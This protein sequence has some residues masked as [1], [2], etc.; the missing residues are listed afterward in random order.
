MENFNTC[1]HRLTR[2]YMPSPRLRV[3]PT[4]WGNYTTYVDNARG[5][6]LAFDEHGRE[7]F[8]SPHTRKTYY[9][10]E[11]GIHVHNK[12]LLSRR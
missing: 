11:D 8:Y 3:F 12:P 6:R 7:F 4:P 10:G 5:V 2:S 9:F 1:A